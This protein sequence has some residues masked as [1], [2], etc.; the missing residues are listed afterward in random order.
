MSRPIR[1]QISLSVVDLEEIEKIKNENNDL[2]NNSDVVKFLLYEYLDTQEKERTES[3]IYNKLSQMDY[4]MMLTQYILREL[5][6]EILGI[7]DTSDLFI[8]A[9]QKLKAKLR[10][11]DN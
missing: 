1:K 5:S 9:E 6:P 7:T 3:N 8:K 11:L 4:E 10:K 2:H